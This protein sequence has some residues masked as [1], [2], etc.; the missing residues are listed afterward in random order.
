M[1]VGTEMT[2]KHKTNTMAVIGKTELSDSFTL[3][4]RTVR[5]RK[6]KN[7]TSFGKQSAFIIYHAPEI[8]KQL[9]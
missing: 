5:V 9:L 4:K 1:S 8:D 6:I 3:A 7:T 2:E